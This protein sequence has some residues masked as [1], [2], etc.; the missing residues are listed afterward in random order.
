MKV[1]SRSPDLV[2][3]QEN[4]LQHGL[5]Q[6]SLLFLFTALAPDYPV[7]P[8]EVRAVAHQLEKSTT[9][10]GH[11]SEVRCHRLLA[12]LNLGFV[13]RSARPEKGRRKSFRESARS[14]RS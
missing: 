8:S 3:R 11:F 5:I 6:E 13:P 9:P 10:R 4:I 7:R 1:T 12:T 2:E 14:S